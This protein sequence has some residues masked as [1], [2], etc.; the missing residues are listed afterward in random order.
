MKSLIKFLS[1]ILLTWS[2]IPEGFSQFLSNLDAGK[3]DPLYTVYAAPPSR[4]NYTADQGYFFR[5]TDDGSGVEFASAEGPSM[6]IAFTKNDRLVFRLD[7]LRREPRITASYSDL[8]KFSYE[9]LEHLE[10]EVFFACYSSETAI[11]QYRMRNKGQFPLTFT[12][13]PYL[14][15]PS[16]DSTNDFNR[17]SK[18]FAFPVLRKR[19]RWMTEHNIPVATRLSGTWTLTGFSTPTGYSWVR[20]T[21]SE[22]GGEAGAPFSGLVASSAKN[23]PGQPY[24]KGIVRS[25]TYRLEPGDMTSF[26]VQVEVRDPVNRSRTSS[27]GTGENIDPGKLIAEDERAYARIPAMKHLGRDQSF[28]YWSSFSLMR[29]CMMPPEGKCSTGYYVFSR[30]PRWGWGYGG[31][32]FHESLSMLAFVYM[33]PEGAMNSQRVYMQRQRPD[34]YI[35]YRT[36]PYLDETIVT[37]GKPTT[38]APW[39]SYINAEIFRITGDRGFLREAYESGAKFYRYFTAERD[40]NANGLCEWGGHAE[41]ESVR[42]AR[43]AVWDNVGWAS[44]FEGPD[45]N[46]MLVKEARSLAMM[47]RA[48]GRPGEAAGWDRD[49]DRRTVLVNRHLWDPETS[50]FYNVNRDNQS[51]TFRAPGDLRIREIIGFLPMWAGISDTARTRLL[52]RS[53]LDTTQFWRRHGIPTLDAS[54]PYYCPIGYWNGPVWVQWNYLLYRAL[55]DYGYNDAASELA[56]RVTG[57]VTW[58]LKNDHTFWEFYSPDERQAG[59]N[60]SYIWAGLAA[61]FLIDESPVELKP[62]PEKKASA[63]R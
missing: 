39:F 2:G 44:N 14:Y 38:S 54:H 36:G 17:V 43:V 31:Q 15:Y 59:W 8:M 51:F 50:F 40:S 55:K 10:V 24:V 1:F 61:R 19:D 6:G 37:G 22:P 46:A 11:C 48:L 35:N 28:L 18:G 58:H 4:S 23:Y 13:H 7:Q 34:G 45:L 60:H 29:Q 25:R 53:L 16:G 5:W 62:G 52:V 47:A 32:V 49:A 41:L 30:E 33:D 57:Q 3:T 42:D 12:V 63:D 27:L 56:S 21:T 26:R 20:R 9:P